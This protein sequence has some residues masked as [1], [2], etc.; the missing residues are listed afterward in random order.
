MTAYTLDAPPHAVPLDSASVRPD[1]ILLLD[2]FFQIVLFHGEHIAQWRNAGY[3]KQPEYASLAAL[4]EGPPQ[5]A[6]E[7]LAERYPI[8]MYVVCDQHGSQ[9]RYLVSKLNPSHTH[10]NAPSSSPASAYGTSSD[11][12]S[13]A[14]SG[15]TVFTDDVN[16]Q[17]FFDHLSKLVVASQ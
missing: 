7:I 4:L 16:L 12:G 5:D 9:A 17:V 10:V 3:H 6:K 1:A 14:S 8:P 2:S 13:S 11:A 15:N